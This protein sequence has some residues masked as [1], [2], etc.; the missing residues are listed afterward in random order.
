MGE[1]GGKGNAPAGTGAELVQG[2]L[3]VTSMYV[4]C[5]GQN[6]KH[7][8]WHT[9]PGED[10]DEDEED[11]TDEDDNGTGHGGPNAAGSK[12]STGAPFFVTV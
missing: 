2:R 4:V 5:V 3:R 7:L 10:G 1:K 8:V 9:I 6:V 11:G 12:G